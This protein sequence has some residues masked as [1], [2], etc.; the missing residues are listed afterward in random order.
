MGAS[1]RGRR[2][3]L[4]SL[5]RTLSHAIFVLAGLLADIVEIYKRQGIHGES[6][7]IESLMELAGAR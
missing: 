3:R 2:G 7:P 4:G 5:P 1:T 6:Y